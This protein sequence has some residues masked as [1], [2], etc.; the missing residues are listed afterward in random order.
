MCG[1]LCRHVFIF[2]TSKFLFGNYTSASQKSFIKMGNRSFLM[3][4][5][6]EFPNL[7]FHTKKE[8]L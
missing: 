1:S 8:L 4:K 5:K 2:N 6:V 7:E 3:S